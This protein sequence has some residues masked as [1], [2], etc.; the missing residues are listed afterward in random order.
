MNY[1]K[2]SSIDLTTLP[3]IKEKKNENDVIAVFNSIS[4]VFDKE[5]IIKATKQLN[6]VNGRIDLIDM[7]IKRQE[8]VDLMNEM[9]L[10]AQMRPLFEKIQKRFLK[11]IRPNINEYKNK[12]KKKSSIAGVRNSLKPRNSNINLNMIAST[13]NLRKSFLTRNSISNSSTDLSPNMI[14]RNSL[15][16]KQ[17]LYSALSSLN[18]IG[19]KKENKIIEEKTI[20]IKENKDNN[21]KNSLNKKNERNNKCIKRD[22]SSMRQVE[23]EIYQFLDKRKSY[24]FLENDKL[25]MKKVFTNLEENVRDKLFSNKK[26]QEIEANNNKEQ[27]AEY[28]SNSLKKNEKNGKSIFNKKR[29]FHK[30]FSSLNKKPEN[31]LHHNQY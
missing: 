20:E 15:I 29:G 25:A 31:S 6:N 21:P 2:R 12:S 22:H 10:I 9:A 30:R 14:A 1:F 27:F 7:I 26:Y 4:D 18:S 13:S 28:F 5:N 17:F 24:K 8:E 16:K 3:C 11:N 19:A 23:D